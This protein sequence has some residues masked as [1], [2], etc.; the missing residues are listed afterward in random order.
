MAASVA[1]PQ[2][3]PTCCQGTKRSG[4]PLMAL[5]AAAYCPMAAENR[6]PVWAWRKMHK[7]KMRKKM[8]KRMGEVYMRQFGWS[9]G[10]PTNM[11][12]FCSCKRLI[13]GASFE[14]SGIALSVGH[15]RASRCLCVAAVKPM[16]DTYTRAVFGGNSGPCIILRV[17]R[18][19]RI[20]V[21]H[22]MTGEFIPASG[23]LFGS[24]LWR[25]KASKS[26]SPA[27]ARMPQESQSATKYFYRSAIATTAHFVLISNT[28]ACQTISSFTRRVESWNLRISRI[29]V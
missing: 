5:F 21:S 18:I 10:R 16:W 28:S 4:S 26:C 25:T 19:S 11:E 14:V 6:H 3:E 1:A 15:V 29:E 2:R 17:A 24:G 8:H 12:E 23:R 22:T 9:V 27:S 20:P 13:S 7:R